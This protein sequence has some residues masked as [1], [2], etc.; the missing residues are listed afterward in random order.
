M[1]KLL[2]IFF[3]LFCFSQ[4][5]TN[6]W[7]FG[8]K[9][10]IYFNKGEISILNNSQMNTPEGCS[11]ISDINGDL[12]FY[13]NG[14]T[15]WNK[16]HE[17]MENGE[18]LASD[19]ENTQTSI[20]IPKPGS[21]ENFYLFTTKISNSTSPLLAQG[22]YYTEIEI[23]NKYPLGKVL[24]KYIRLIGG[25]SEKISAVHHADG[26]SIWV[27][28]YT[29]LSGLPNSPINALTLFKIDETGINSRIVSIQEEI[30]SK[31]GA[32]K[33]SP[34]GKYIA[35]S[36]YN[37]QFIYLYNFN[38]ENGTVNLKERIFADTSLFSPK[39]VYGLEF[40][41]DSK[42]L[43][44]T[45]E[46][47]QTGISTV[48]QYIINS[49]TNDPLFPKKTQ[50]F[51]SKD[52]FFG[53]LQLANN[54]KIYVALCNKNTNSIISSEKIGVI[55]FPQKINPEANYQH[56]SID[57]ET[58]A[59]NKGLPN[60]ISSYFRNRIITE[61]KCAFDLF[62]FSLDSY[63]P[64]TS[65]SWDFG[66]NSNTSTN[67]NPTHTYT[68]PGNYIVTATITINNQQQNIYKKVKVFPLPEL[69]KNQKL[70]QCD[71]NNDGISLFNLNNINDKISKDNSLTYTFYKSLKEAQTNSNPILNPENFHNESNPQVIYTKAVSINGCTEIESFTI[72]SLFKPSIN[73]VPI[74]ECEIPNSNS[75][76][77]FDLQ[78]KKV[79]L[80]A[81]LNLSKLYKISFF[82][83]FEDAQKSTN[84]LPNLF[85]SSTTTIWVKIEN[86]NECSGISSIQLIVNN[87]PIIAINDSYTICV[88]PA[89]H[90]PII[91]NADNQNDKFEWKD[92]NDNILSTNSQ[93]TLTKTGKF[94]LTVYKTE[95]GVQCSTSKDFLVDNPTSPNV[96][97]L[98]VSFENEQSNTVYIS[99]NGNS[100]Y[101]YSLDNINFFGSGASHTFNEV[102]PGINTIYVRDLLKCEPVI[103]TDVS[104]IGYSKFLTPNG[105][106][107][108][109]TWIIYGLKSKFFK[110]IDVTIFN[111]FGR[112]LYTINN[113]NAE[114][115]WNGTLNGKLLPPNDYWFYAKLTDLKDNIIEK[116][117]NFSLQKN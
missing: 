80:N 63:A 83:T 68:S 114:Q 33:V 49:D 69:I 108:N 81:L 117:G 65:V 103:S 3:P 37:K 110:K 25:S 56:L 78:S 43:Y 96:T 41:S 42:I 72:E 10:G 53:S 105:D 100:S 18:G 9:G 73:I 6:N 106:D 94:S 5:E 27:M 50:I 88:N 60:F 44:Y 71:D 87:L 98:D 15:V 62:E 45:A 12:L 47:G 36:D 97:N 39:Y 51:S 99:V 75:E 101:E 74:I 13:T 67:I 64:I 8:D 24:F 95:N 92:I 48:N 109:D 14:Q 29:S 84:E 2:F 86:E 57:L 23:S 107:K 55:N 46:I 4:N 32:M 21:K 11:T 79:E 58:G 26:K 85:K 90:S 31:K 112:V 19:K 40:S 28:T 77:N 91:L 20:I 102:Q 70:V 82:P 7:Y 104:V 52:E 16:N 30:Q 61:N 93:F 113:Q 1:K 59:S 38:N 111:R 34:D 35:V 115:G 66:D 89:I 22:I 76:S 17:I 54:S 116:K